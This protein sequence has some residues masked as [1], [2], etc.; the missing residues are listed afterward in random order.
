[1][2]LPSLMNVCTIYSGQSG[3]TT[4]PL[5]IWSI[6]PSQ[7]VLWTRPSHFR[8]VLG[9]FTG[10]EALLSSVTRPGGSSCPIT[11][12]PTWRPVARSRAGRPLRCRGEAKRG[13]PSESSGWAPKLPSLKCRCVRFCTLGE[14]DAHDR[15]TVDAVGLSGRL[16][17]VAIC[18]PPCQRDHSTSKPFPKLGDH[19]GNWKNR[20]RLL[21]HRGGDS[22]DPA[23]FRHVSLIRSKLTSIRSPRLPSQ[24]F[25]IQD[26]TAEA[27]A[28]SPTLAASEH[29]SS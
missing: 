18:A 10:V 22:S 20:H 27:K 6:C 17:L 24:P 25:S 19:D 2:P 14:F 28:A 16:Q 7:P 1:L 3:R 29:C 11:S 13:G 9:T 15:E 21:R 26:S 4:D 8:T 5:D 12:S 23:N